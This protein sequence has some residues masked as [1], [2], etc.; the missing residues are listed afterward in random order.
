MID[1]ALLRNCLNCIIQIK[2]LSFLDEIP[3]N[4]EQTLKTI[5]VFKTSVKY[6]KEIKSLS[7]S[8]DQ[9]GKWNFDLEDCDNI[10]RVEAD[11]SLS[12]SILNFM[13]QKGYCCE[14]LE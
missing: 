10:L 9:F 14:E 7:K 1:K 2:E 3:P 13:H 8:L 12:K 5:F 11:V 6:N 4:S